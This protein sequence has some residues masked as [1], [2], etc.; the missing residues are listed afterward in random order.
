MTLHIVTGTDD[1]YVAGVLVLMA[2]AAFHTPDVRFTVLDLGISPANRARLDA[3]EKRLGKPVARIEVPGGVFDHIPVRRAH[4]TRG[5]FLR[6]LV[7]QL[8]PDA[9]RVL[10]MDCDM[11]VLGDLSF[12]AQLP[13]GDVPIAAVPCPSPS[14][15]EL[16]A[17][18]VARGDY[19]NAGLLLMNLPV[20]RAES[21]AEVMM[22]RLAGDETP[23]LSGDEAAMNLIARG[24]IERLPAGLNVYSDPAAFASTNLLPRDVRVVHYVVNNKPWKGP[25]AMDRLWWFHADRIADLMPPAHNVTLRE[26]LKRI[27]RSRRMAT[28]LLLGREKYRARRDVARAME[29][30]VDGYL[31]RWSAAAPARISER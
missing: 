24:R 8:M 4:L 7:P 3:L 16:D 1:N 11:V 10:Y 28:G 14:Q 6:L 5:T 19:V 12:L 25:V 29:R 18:G 20:W 26:R 17:I 2:S 27:N 22:R 13:L 31:T 23:V 15:A 30:M 21:T 9:D